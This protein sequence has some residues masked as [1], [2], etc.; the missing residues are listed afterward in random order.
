MKIARMSFSRTVLMHMGG[1]PLNLL[2]DMLSLLPPDSTMV[3]CGNDPV[4]FLDYLFFTSNEF[5]EI[6]D[7]GLVPDLI[8]H[9]KMNSDGTSYVD[10]IDFGDVLDNGQSCYHIWE[11]AHG[12]SNSYECCKNCGVKKP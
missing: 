3:G 9:F 10:K 7:A 11:V 5:K 4:S 1:V 2:K 12:F 6:P 8:P